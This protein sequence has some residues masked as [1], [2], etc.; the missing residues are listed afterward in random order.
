MS[1]VL[2][3]DYRVADF[4]RWWSAVAHDSAS[5]AGLGAHHFVAYRS[6]EDPNRVFVT[7]GVR[8][9]RPLEVL[10]SSPDVATWFDYSGVEDVPPV[11]AGQV[12]E[13]LTL[14]PSTSNFI[15]STPV[16][17]AGIVPIPDFDRFWAHVHADLP[18]LGESGVLKYWAYRAL[19]DPS[20]VMLLREIASEQHARQWLRYPEATAKWISRAG[21]GVYPP[22]FIGRLIKSVPVPPVAP[23]S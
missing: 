10:L 15:G 21:G 4:D 12:I 3:A 18:R 1:L 16:I 20:E 8:D 7:I 19:D 11:F 23:A 2:A 17:V 6:I 14:H 22:M 9:R 5:L 13:K